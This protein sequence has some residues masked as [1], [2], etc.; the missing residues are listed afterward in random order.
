MPR[1]LFGEHD[2]S[3]GHWQKMAVARPFSREASILVLD[4][5]TS[6]LSIQTE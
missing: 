4:K 5:P 6:N 2:P 3:A 1:R